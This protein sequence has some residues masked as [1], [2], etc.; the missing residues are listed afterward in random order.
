LWIFQSLEKL[1]CC[2]GS[3]VD[4]TRFGQEYRGSFAELPVFVL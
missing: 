1:R 2:A 4:K 3:L